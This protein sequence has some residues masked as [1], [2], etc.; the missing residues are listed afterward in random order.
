M[1]DGRLCGNGKGPIKPGQIL[2]IYGVIFP[3]FVDYVRSELIEKH[4]HP[5][6]H[7]YARQDV[8]VRVDELIGEALRKEAEGRRRSDEEQRTRKRCCSTRPPRPRRETVQ[9]RSTALTLYRSPRQI[10]DLGK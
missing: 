1:N 6:K 4:V 10:K 3:L 9:H 7:A 5:R 2:R 8:L